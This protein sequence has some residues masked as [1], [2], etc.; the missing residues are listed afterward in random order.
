M[1]LKSSKGGKSR[2]DLIS[3]MEN[4]YIVHSVMGAHTANPTSGDF[5]VTTSTILKVVDGQIAGPIKQAGLSGN[6]AKALSKD[7]FLGDRPIIQDS[8]STGGMHIPDV[9]VMDG[10]R[11]NPA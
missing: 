3:H 9:L 5:S 10:F 7:V 4:G 1:I 8:Y 6:I 2:D 11:I